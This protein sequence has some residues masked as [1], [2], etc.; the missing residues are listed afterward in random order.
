MR[1]AR[2]YFERALEMRQSLYPK[3]KYPQ[4][5]PDLASTLSNLG[6]LLSLAGN[7]G[8]ARSIP[9]SGGSRCRRPFT[10]GATIHRATPQIADDPGR[11]GTDLAELQGDSRSGTAVL[12]EGARDEQGALSQRAIPPR[13]SPARRSVERS[14]TTVYEDESIEFGTRLL[15]VLCWTSIGALYPEG[16]PDLA[17]DLNDLAWVLA[18]EGNY[19]PAEE[20]FRQAVRDLSSVLSQG[21]LSPGASSAWL[22]AW[23][24]WDSWRTEEGESCPRLGPC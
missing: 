12:F 23:P 17:T 20:Q 2:R 13:L 16:H 8:E 22:R 10:P 15:A 11:P 4:G 9:L 21:K 14:R 19:G 3:D 18:A 7:P 1:E 24:I 6:T 5:H